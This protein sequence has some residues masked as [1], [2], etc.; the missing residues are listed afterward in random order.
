MPMRAATAAKHKRLTRDFFRELAVQAG[1]LTPDSFADQFTVLIDGTLIL[2]H[3]HNRDDA[4]AAV[5]PLV[6]ALVAQYIP[7]EPKA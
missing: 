3:V 7:A 2:R 4:V 1:A 5:R 6:E